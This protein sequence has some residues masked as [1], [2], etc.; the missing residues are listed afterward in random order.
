MSASFDP[1]AL[2]HTLGQ[3]ATGVTVVTC[4]GPDGERVGMTANSF[5]S[6][7]LEPPLVLWS[8][9]RKARSFAAFAAARHFAFSILA[10]DQADLSNR[11]SRPGT[12]KFEGV[13]LGEGAGGVPLIADAAAHFECEQHASVDGGDHLV[14]IGRVTRFERR[15]RRGL[16]FAQGRYG[17]VAPHPGTVGPAPRDVAAL[18]PY[19]DFL[20]PLLF[21]AYNHLFRALSGTLAAEDATGPQMRVLAIL[22]ACG[23]TDDETLLT[24]TMLSRSSFTDARRSLIEAGFVADDGVR[25]TITPAG[26]ARL[27]VLLQQA[28]AMEER[29]TAALDSTEAEM[30]RELLRKL[31]RHHEG[32]L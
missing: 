31:V 1:R 14:I 20:V 28:A 17:V 4:L 9:D 22:T 25:A 16:V 24:R 29:S 5:A 10:Q 21:R 13:A 7:S 6:V 30:L 27:A 12:E 15:E 23:A 32:E 3:F 2:R 19:D 26:E 8:V 11:F 18:H